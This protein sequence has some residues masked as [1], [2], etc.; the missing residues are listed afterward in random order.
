MSGRPRRKGDRGRNR[1]WDLYLASPRNRLIG[2]ILTGVSVV[3]QIL[4]ATV[5]VV[6]GVP[7]VGW[8]LVALLV[9]LALLRVGLAIRE[10]RL[11][12]FWFPIFEADAEALAH[13]A[14]TPLDP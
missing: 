5:L 2:K 8:V 10:A 1:A 4:V 13:E 7:F 12:R 6:R 14:P 9:A 3:F 11:M